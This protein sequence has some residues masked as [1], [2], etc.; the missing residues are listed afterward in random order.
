MLVGYETYSHGGS[1]VCVTTLKDLAASYKIK[2]APSY[3]LAIPTVAAHLKIGI[4]PPKDVYEFI[5][6]LIIISKN[7]I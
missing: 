1:T 6:A 7:Y 5:V 4:V 2:Y 3:Y